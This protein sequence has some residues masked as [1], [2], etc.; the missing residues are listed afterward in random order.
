[1]PVLVGW[2][3]VTNSLGWTPWVMFGVIFCWTPPHSWA[4]AVKYADDYRAASVPML[5][6]VASMEVTSR[7]MLAWTVVLVA[8]TMVLAPVAHLGVIY[9]GTAAI[10]G[11]AFLGL[12][13]DLHRR[14]TMARSM[15]LF[16]FSISYVTLLFGA[17]AVDVL[18]RYGW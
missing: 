4:L 16:A 8:V 1:M 15:R 10:L 7:R 2:A 18:V 11:A 17:M 6:A 9:W 5:P 13:I 12:C 3:A 14:P